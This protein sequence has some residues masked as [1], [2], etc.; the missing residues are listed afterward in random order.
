MAGAEI[1]ASI[2]SDPLAVATF[3]DNFPGAKVVLGRLDETNGA[4]LLGDLRSVDLLLASPECTNHSVARGARE[5]DEA[6][7]RSGL[8]VLPFVRAWQPRFLVL[9][10]VSRMQRWEGWSTFLAALTAAGYYHSVLI[11]DARHFGVP[12]AR[13]RMFLLASRGLKPPLEIP[14]SAAI[15]LTAANVL[16]RPGTHPA[17]SI[18]ERDRPLA[19]ATMERIKRGRA[20]VRGTRD[21]IIVYYGSDAAGGWQPLDRPLRTL[22]TL[23]RFGLVSGVGE[24][25]TLRM[26][27]VPELKRAMG[28]PEEF[29]LEQGS[30]RDRVRLLGNAV[31]PPVMKSVIEALTGGVKAD[32]T[33]RRVAQGTLDR[34]HR[35]RETQI[36]RGGQS[37]NNNREILRHHHAFSTPATDG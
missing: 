1:I 20:G 6:S 17:R 31:C 33:S 2:D 23:D 18:Y 28:F 13:R 25:A 8:H 4:Q 34:D 37:D 12:Q 10:N 11:L 7:L 9:E 26:L 35:K 32:R 14:A 5:I 29:K 16:D 22:T 27:Q 19:E 3:K 15:P 36:S 24:K 21:F 30:R